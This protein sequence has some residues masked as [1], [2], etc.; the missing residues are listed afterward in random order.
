M[1][2]KM[3]GAVLVMG[4][5]LFSWTGP[6]AAQDVAKLEDL[7]INA[8]RTFERFSADPEM[9]WFRNNLADAKG[10]MIVPRSVK[11]GFIFGGSGG[12]GV[13]LTRDSQSGKWSYPAFYSMGSVTFGAQIGGDVSEIVLLVMTEKG[14]DSLLSG[15]MKLGGDVSVAAGPVGAGVGG[16]TSD[17]LTYIRSKGAFVGATVAGALIS[18]RDKWNAGYYDKKD[19]RP[20]DIIV[21]RS[22]VNLQ[23]DPLRAVVENAAN[24]P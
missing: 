6:L 22:V 4:L 20:I 10:I 21:H 14:I 23:S 3:I 7:V 13:F 17:I 1:R 8:A 2:K 16:K 19:V 5:F 9:S 12:S 18:P 11:A 15:S 24:K